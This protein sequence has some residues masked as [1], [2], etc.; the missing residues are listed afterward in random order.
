M[1]KMKTKRA[2]AKR[3]KR[4]A[5]GKLKRHSGWKGHLLEAKQPKRRRK[6]RKAAL[7]SKADEPRLSV[8][9]PYL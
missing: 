5:S 8:L 4:T 1:P 2:A 3:L 6:L 9:V 7:I